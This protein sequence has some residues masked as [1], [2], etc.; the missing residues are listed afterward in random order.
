MSFSTEV[1][2]GQ[3]YIVL[4]GVGNPTN[5]FYKNFL[6]LGPFTTSGIVWA[7]KFK[8]S[9]QLWQHAKRKKRNKKCGRPIWWHRYNILFPELIRGR[10]ET[11]RRCELVTLAFDLETGAQCNTCRVVPSCLFWWYCDYS[12]LVPEPGNRESY[13]LK[14]IWHKILGLGLL[15]LSSVWLLQAS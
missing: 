14:G 10:D 8:Y 9:S 11:Y 12:V 15:S 13:G 4:D 6:I 7:K 2:L 1:G 5:L 3:R